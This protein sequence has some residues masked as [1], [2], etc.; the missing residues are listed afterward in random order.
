M[1]NTHSEQLVTAKTLWQRAALAAA[2]LPPT[3]RFGTSSWNYEGWQGLL[4]RERYSS[5]RE[6]RER[7][8]GEYG[9]FPLFRTVGIDSAL[10][11]PP[12]PTTLLR[13]A[14]QLPQG[15]LWVSKVW[16]GITVP[17]FPGH[18]RYGDRAGTL[19]RTFLD[20]EAFHQQFLRLYEDP[21]VFPHCGPFVLQFPWLHPEVI[22]PVEFTARLDRFLGAL[23]NKFRYAVE[24]RNR[25]LLSKQYFEVLNRHGVTHCF[26]HWTGMPPLR[27]QMLAAANCG[28]ISASF[29]VARILTPLG[30]TYEAAVRMFRPYDRLQRVN[31][32][33]R[34]DVMTL[35]RRAVKRGSE[36]FVLVNN[37]SE[38]CAPLTI[39][40]MSEH[41]VATGSES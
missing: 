11:A 34:A 4:Y 24:I 35:L 27:E 23:P 10:Y 22:A 26:N 28:G 1:K 32:M 5:E 18:E 6:L 31:E 9:T 36:V 3:I 40:E 15:F 7:A 21:K 41:F 12:R 20:G 2:S 29:L 8:L 25:E 16:E 38:G 14:E 30:V 17:R 39:L 13:Y 19:N 33:M 37:R